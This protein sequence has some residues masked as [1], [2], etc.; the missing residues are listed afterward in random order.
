MQQSDNRAAMIDLESLLTVE[1]AIW[2]NSIHFDAKSCI[3][4]TFRSKSKSDSGKVSKSLEKF[5]K[6]SKILKNQ[7]QV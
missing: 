7:K 6:P 4:Q 2:T 1:G 3:K 5:Q